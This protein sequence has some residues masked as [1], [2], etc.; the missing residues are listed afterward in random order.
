[1]A[2]GEGPLLVSTDT[3]GI[4]WINSKTDV[5]KGKEGQTKAQPGLPVPGKRRPACGPVPGTHVSAS[6]W[7]PAGGEGLQGN[8]RR[9]AQ[10]WC[11]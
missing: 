2:C 6:N 9:D 10:V 1:M 3:Y 8:L 4:Q 5:K 7:N 11:L